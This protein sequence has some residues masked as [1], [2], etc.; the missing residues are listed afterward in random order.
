MVAAAI[1]FTQGATVGLAGQALFGVQTTT[2]NVTNGNDTNVVNWT[3]GVVDVPPAS[4]IPVGIAQSGGSNSWTF[5]PDSTDSFLISLTV[6]DS[7]GNTATDIRSFTVK[8]GSG[9]WIPPF[10]ATAAM[11]NFA[12]A[13]RG[14]AT[15]MEAWLDYLDGLSVGG[16]SPPILLAVGLT[17]ATSA[18]NVAAN[19]TVSG[20]KVRVITPYSAGATLA[21]GHTS[22]TSLIMAANDVDLVN[23]IAG[24]IYDISP[25]LMQAWGGTALPLI[26]TVGGSPSVGSLQVLLTSAVDLT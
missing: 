25:G 23:C 18:N 17:T 19:A 3:F 1:K 14:W 24:T 26:A 22:A 13:T 21:L 2:V 16:A 7:L 8:R 5:A 12:G 20:G 4:S 10:S 9:R 11:L 15:S 6:E